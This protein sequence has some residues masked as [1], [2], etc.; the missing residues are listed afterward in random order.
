MLKT[1]NPYIPKSFKIAKI[2][3][4]TH[5]TSTFR[6]NCKTK[7]MPGQFLEASVLGIGECPISI[8]S[9]SGDY[10]DLC[11]RD[12]GNVTKAIHSKKAGN[13]IWLRGPYG[14][15]YPMEEM[16]GRD[17]CL[18]GGGTGVAPLIGVLEYIE[19]NRK[20]F[21]NVSIYFGFR[22]PHDML[23]RRHFSRWRKK[24]SLNLT[25]DKA[26]G[27]W[28]GNVGVVTTLLDKANIS[29]DS[30]ALI[31]GPPVM[32]KFVMQSL[33]KKGIQE[34]NVYISFERLMSCG[35]GKC[36]H[37]ELGGKYVCKDGPVFRY[38]KAKG[39]VD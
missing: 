29:K 21:G 17:I 1:N 20:A 32:I 38:D 31:C 36:G 34:E 27:G 9:C 26:G 24:F 10:V 23:F 30:V 6:I 12:V 2:F 28:K 18:V 19:K 5:D 25:V 14:K 15:G 13:R 8:C 4:E 3:R 35:I 11:I 37:C 7:H 16:Y 22:F 39:M 33:G